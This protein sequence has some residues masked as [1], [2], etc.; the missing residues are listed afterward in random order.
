MAGMIILSLAFV[1]GYAGLYIYTLSEIQY[2]GMD[3][4]RINDI[5]SSGFTVYGNMEIYN[6]GIV[7]VRMDNITYNVLLDSGREIARGNIQGKTLEPK[8]SREFHFSSRI[9]WVPTTDVALRLLSPESTYATINGTVNVRDIK[10]IKFDIPFRKEVDI[11][12]YVAQFISA[13][14]NKTTLDIAGSLIEALT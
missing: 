8:T 4:S 13:K 2:H 6:G 3:V 9:N 11:E 1:F 10:F 12:P 7:E 14:L 5:D